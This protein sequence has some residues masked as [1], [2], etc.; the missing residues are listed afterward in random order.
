MSSLWS[1]VR[2]AVQ[3]VAGF[4]R[5]REEE[6]DMR[7]EMQFHIDAHAAKLMQS[8][9]SPADA[10]RRALVAFGGGQRCTEEARDQLRSLPIETIARDTRTALRGLRAHPGFALSTIATIGLGIAAAVTVFSFVD[11]IF[12]RPLP[13]PSADRLVR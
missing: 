13:V 6:R 11:S 5:L 10:R 1:R 9:M 7:D 3:L 2:S 4:R 8:G 12:L